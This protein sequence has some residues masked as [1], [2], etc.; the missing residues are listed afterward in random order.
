MAEKP[1]SEDNDRDKD[2][3][4]KDSSGLKSTVDIK[5]E[6]RKP[7]I[8]LVGKID[9]EKASK[10]KTDKPAPPKEEPSKKPSAPAATAAPVAPAPPAEEKVEKK[11]LDAEQPAAAEEE[12]KKPTVD[13]RIVGKI[14]LD[15][16][17]KEKPA[18]RRNLRKNRSRRPLKKKKL[19]THLFKPK[20]RRKRSLRSLPGRY[21]PNQL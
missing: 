9:L 2:V 8:K 3:L 15:T 13:I 6:I 7:D 12:K 4:V 14:D 5:T 1:Q 19:K 17:T 18:K 21:L 10:P 20:K 11:K 16:I